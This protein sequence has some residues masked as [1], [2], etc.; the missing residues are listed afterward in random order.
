MYLTVLLST[1]LV[2]CTC[3]EI[4]ISNILPR[5]NTTGHIIDAHDGTYNK[6]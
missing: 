3:T 2:A 1:L 5:V 4:T 6:W